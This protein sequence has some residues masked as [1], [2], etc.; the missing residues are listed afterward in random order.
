MPQHKFEV[1][2]GGTEEDRNE[3][4]YDKQARIQ[5]EDAVEE[6]RTLEGALTYR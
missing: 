3:S 1:I 2:S 4:E 5:K 6:S